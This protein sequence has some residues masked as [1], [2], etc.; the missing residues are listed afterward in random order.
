MIISSHFVTLDGVIGSPEQWHPAFMSPESIDVMLTQ[1][2]RADGLLLGRRTFEEFAAYWPR[3]GDDVM[4]AK[5]T[6]AIR[7]YVVS[8][9]LSDPDWGPTEVLAGDPVRSVN[10]LTEPGLT[11]WLTGGRL[12]RTLLAAGMIDEVQFY[13][14]PF[15]A[16]HGLR[17][18]D[19]LHAQLRLEL[20]QCTQLPNGVLHLVYG[21][22]GPTK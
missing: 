8:S 7:K 17:L 18:F 19:G 13:L 20:A 11:L 14:D 22:G 12:T 2:A 6:N 5:E 4:A 1:L 16:G 9:T 21:P 15:V 10:T 3:Q